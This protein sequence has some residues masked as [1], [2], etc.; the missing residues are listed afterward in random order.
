MS[1]LVRTS[2]GS[3]GLPQIQPCEY[4]GLAQIELI[5]RGEMWLYEQSAILF[6]TCDPETK[7]HATTHPSLFLSGPPLLAWFSIVVEY[8]SLEPSSLKS[9]DAHLTFAM[10]PTLL[11]TVLPQAPP[12]RSPPSTTPL[13]TLMSPERFP[14]CN[15]H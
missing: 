9:D 12:R 13:S 14:R 3:S 4:S 1:G 7:P 5:C 15:I 11:H 10:M 6:P 2:T 8:F